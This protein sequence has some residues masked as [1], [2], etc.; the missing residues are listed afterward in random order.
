MSLSKEQLDTIKTAAS[1]PFPFATRCG[2]TVEELERGYCK[3][4]MPLEPNIN[5]IGTMYAGALFTLAELPGG[6]IFL[7]TFDT[8]NF[9]P[10]VKDMQIRFRRPAKT[11][12]TVEVRISEEE[13]LRIQSEA[14]ANGKADFEWECDLKDT[15]GEV[16]AICRNL[17]QLRKI[18]M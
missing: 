5:H 16:V 4:R 15:S 12:I 7:S 17:Y 18:G 13:V 2:S 8:R 6:V 3:M 10:I 1:T 9:Y 14:E 11:D